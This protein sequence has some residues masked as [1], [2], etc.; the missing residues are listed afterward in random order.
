MSIGTYS[1][2]MGDSPKENLQFKV[3]PTSISCP[4]VFPV[5]QMEKKSHLPIFCILNITSES[6]EKRDFRN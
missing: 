1:I 3:N 4:H 2:D 5:L 6:Y